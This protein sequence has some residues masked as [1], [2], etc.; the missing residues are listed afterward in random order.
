MC[1]GRE[2]SSV[3]NAERQGRSGDGAAMSDSSQCCVHLDR[4]A[5][6]FDFV[7]TAFSLVGRSLCVADCRLPRTLTSIGGRDECP[8]T[9]W[10]LC[11]RAI[12]RVPAGSVCAD[13]ASILRIGIEQ[14]R[15]TRLSAQQPRL[16]RRG[17]YQAADGVAVD[18]ADTHVAGAGD[19][20]FDGPGLAVIATDR[21]GARR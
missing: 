19:V 2:R 14:R 20:H 15:E 8:R 10:V 21:F 7:S 6:W 1:N 18:T 16:L 9:V 13:P 4:P 11:S 17:W 3:A 12:M 5:E